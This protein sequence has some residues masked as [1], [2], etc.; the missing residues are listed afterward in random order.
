MGIIDQTVYLISGSTRLRLGAK[1]RVHNLRI[2]GDWMIL[3]CL[4]W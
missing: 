3:S 2:L 4:A 1:P